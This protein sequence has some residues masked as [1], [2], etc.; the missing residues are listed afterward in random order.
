MNKDT[1]MLERKL[2]DSSRYVFS[3]FYRYVLLYYRNPV[4]STVSQLQILWRLLYNRPCY[5]QQRG[6]TAVDKRDGYANHTLN[7]NT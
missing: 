5:G 7:S 1:A 2:S 6:P 4:N 3:G